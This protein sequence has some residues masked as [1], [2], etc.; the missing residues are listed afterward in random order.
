MISPEQFSN[1]LASG[2]HWIAI[3]GS[4][5]DVSCWCQAHPGGKLVLLHSAG[6]DVSEAFEAYHPRWVRQRLAAFKVGQLDSEPSHSYPA[7]ADQHP[8][9]PT[10]CA[11]PASQ[12][13]EL[14]HAVQSTSS[15]PNA[16]DNKADVQMISREVQQSRQQKLTAADRLKKVQ[17]ALEAQGLFHTSAAFYVKLAACCAACLAWS[18]WCIMQQHVVPGAL[19]LGLFWQ[20]VSSSASF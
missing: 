8:S 15:S 9:Q 4:V 5:Y 2:K 19:L 12:N 13:D 14:F 6:R 18:I 10:P 7:T 17:R 20:Q 1:I 11:S 16:H 3:D